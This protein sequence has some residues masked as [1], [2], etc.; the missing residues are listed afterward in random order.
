MS[1]ISSK[2]LLIISAEISRQLIDSS[3]KMIITTCA[4]VP[5]LRKAAELAKKNIPIVAIQTESQ[6]EE[7][8]RG[9]I[10]FAELT[11]PIGVDF[12]SLVQYSRS[13]E[14]VAFLPYSSGTTGLAKGVQLTHS[15]LTA[16]CEMLDVEMNNTRLILPTTSTFQD[17]LP[18]VLPF[19][20]IYGFTCTLSSKLSQGCKLVTLPKFQPDTF[21]NSLSHY[22]GT[23]VHLVPPIVLFLGHHPNLEKKHVDSI[24]IVMS[25]A[26]PIGA[27]DAERMQK[28]MPQIKFIQ[29]YGLTET[30]PCAMFGEQGYTN[31]QSVGKPL[32]N[33]EAK[34]VDLT[35]GTNTGLGPGKVGELLVRGPHV[36]KGY[37]NNEQATKEIIVENGW[38]RTGDISYY[39][40]DGNFYIT[41]RLKELIKVKG[42]QVPPAELEAVIRQH[43]MVLDAAVVGVPHEI[44]GEAPRAFVVVKPDGA[45]TEEELKEF[46]AERVAKFKHLE[47]GVRFLES[48]PKNASGK[49]L[50]REI[51]EKFC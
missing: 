8:P 12:A 17:V 39:D 48:I 35:D 6:D 38:L 45:V 34:I 19:F 14:D 49:I 5:V 13:I 41:D 27:S 21:L 37:L 31:Y 40:E 3:T 51:K 10:S 44:N 11:S 24:R 15:N 16:N 29:G 22:K 47:G 25:G 18:C 50:R 42:F 43:P 32:S 36:M 2:T 20:H 4:L 1:T 33:T 30:S 46:V 23:M 26:A 28:R 7:I 9:A